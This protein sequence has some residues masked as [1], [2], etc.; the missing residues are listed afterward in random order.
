MYLELDNFFW[1]VIKK[2]FKS[3]AGVVARPFY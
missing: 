3:G 2:V 1:L